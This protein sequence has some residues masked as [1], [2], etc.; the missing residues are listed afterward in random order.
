MWFCLCER[1]YDEAGLSYL[2]Y[3]WCGYVYMWKQVG[4]NFASHVVHLCMFHCFADQDIFCSADLLNSESVYLPVPGHDI[5]RSPDLRQRTIRRRC[6]V[7]C[8]VQRS[9]EDT[10]KLVPS[11]LRQLCPSV[12]SRSPVLCSGSFYPWCDGIVS[13]AVSQATCRIPF[14]SSEVSDVRSSLHARAAGEMSVGVPFCGSSKSSSCGTIVRSQPS[15]SLDSVPTENV[16]LIHRV[17]DSKRQQHL[18]AAN[19]QLS[20]TG[21]LKAKCRVLPPATVGLRSKIRL[22]TLGAL[23]QAELSKLVMRQQHAEQLSRFQDMSQ[24]QEPSSEDHPH[25]H[26]RCFIHSATDPR[27]AN[28]NGEGSWE[29]G[30]CISVKCCN[31][32]LNYL[33]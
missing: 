18:H 21:T 22:K 10:R 13:R 3:V 7:T 25:P 4:K 1:I 15:S 28:F 20:T 19:S 26:S 33:C 32:S 2:R 6:H 12:G 27:V 29:V 30:L 14:H 8:A 11:D 24:P 5:S 23:R 17:V 31:E 16:S 9:Q